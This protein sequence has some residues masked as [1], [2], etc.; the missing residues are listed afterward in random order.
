M[1]NHL[2]ALLNDLAVTDQREGT[3]L[4]TERD[5]W[6]AQVTR[7]SLPLYGLDLRQHGSRA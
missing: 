2:D 1:S 5:P 6:T 4:L 7:V 3:L